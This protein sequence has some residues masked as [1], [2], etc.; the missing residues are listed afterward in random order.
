LQDLAA[1]PLP[2][3]FSGAI[4][5]WTVG[6]FAETPVRTTAMLRVHNGATLTSVTLTWLSARG[7]PRARLLRYDASGDSTP[8]TRAAGD[9]DGWTLLPAP[10]AA[11]DVQTADIGCDPGVVVDKR[12]YSYGLQI[13]EDQTL[14]SPVYL[15]KQAARAAS[16]ANLADLH[17]API[18]DGVQ[19]VAG[20]IIL[21][22][23]QDDPRENGL[24]YVWD[25]SGT[26]LHPVGITSV[27][28][29]FPSITYTTSLGVFPVGYVVPVTDG[30]T[31]GGTFWQMTLKSGG[32]SGTFNRLNADVFEIDGTDG[33]VLASWAQTFEPFA[34]GNTYIAVVAHHSGITDTRWQ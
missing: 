26:H 13:E 12:L 10:D 16:T 22:R 34:L 11:I 8:I 17:G 21:L 31:L 14:K 6:P 29:S 4:E 28:G 27:T 25:S 9:A 7:R 30:A 20:D 33:R 18:I 24:W 23:A 15:L 32:P 5:T 2:P 3:P 1:P 19:T